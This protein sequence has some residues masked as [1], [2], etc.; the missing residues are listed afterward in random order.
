M[1]NTTL[2]PSLIGI[3]S[4]IFTFLYSTLKFTYL[5]VPLP[6][7]PFSKCK[8]TSG[9]LTLIVVSSLITSVGAL[10][11]V[12]VSSP[13]FGAVSIVVVGVDSE[14]VVASIVSATVVVI[15]VVGC[16]VVTSSA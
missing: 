5:P 3:E 10:S 6:V 4:G 1:V 12:G 7:S 2:S 15:A 14:A 9:F 13:V 8:S 16:V 11:I